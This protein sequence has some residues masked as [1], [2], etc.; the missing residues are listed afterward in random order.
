MS[1]L[2][3]TVAHERRRRET[4]EAARDA[5]W[6]AH[7]AE[8]FPKWAHETVG[9]LQ[10]KDAAEREATL[11]ELLSRDGVT[12]ETLADGQKNW[13]G[14]YFARRPCSCAGDDGNPRG[15]PEFLCPGCGVASWCSAECMAADT[16]HA[17]SCEDSRIAGG[18]QYRKEFYDEDG[19]VVAKAQLARLELGDTWH[20]ACDCWP[21]DP[22]QELNDA[23]NLGDQ[24][25]VARLLDAGLPVDFMSPLTGSMPALVTAAL[26]GYLGLATFLVDRGADVNKKSVLG[27]TPAIG[28]AQ[29]DHVDILTLLADR[30]ADL[31]A[32]DA[33]GLTALAA[34][35]EQQGSDGPVIR[36]RLAAL[37]FLLERGADPDKVD[38]D[39]DGL[40]AP[41]LAVAAQ[42]LAAAMKRG[43]HADAVAAFEAAIELLCEHGASA[44]GIEGH[45]P[46]ISVAV[47]SIRA[48]ATLL[49]AGADPNVAMLRA[50]C[51]TLAFGDHQTMRARIAATWAGWVG[52]PAEE[53]VDDG[54]RAPHTTPLV[55]V[56]RSTDVAKSAADHPSLTMLMDFGADPNRIAIAT[57][58]LYAVLRR[59]AR[60]VEALLEAGADPDAALVLMGC[61]S[62][63]GPWGTFQVKEEA[64]RLI[65]TS[66]FVR[67]HF[68]PAD[69]V[70]QAFPAVA[71]EAAAAALEEESR[72]IEINRPGCLEAQDLRRVLNHV[73][74]TNPALLG[75]LDEY[76]ERVTTRP[77]HEFGDIFVTPES[78]APLPGTAARSVW[79]AYC[80]WRQA[81]TI[82]AWDQDPAQ[83]HVVRTRADYDAA[84]AS[85]GSSMR[86]SWADVKRQLN[87]AP[88]PAPPA[89]AGVSA[90]IIREL[91]ARRAVRLPGFVV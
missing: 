1:R 82:Q 37:A 55:E 2:R 77:N 54:T 78:E 66:E 12:V 85:M 13:T 88:V 38:A 80:C 70:R 86:T 61:T 56:L 25:E 84:R 51:P 42:G 27:C 8:V 23:A 52:P 16:E 53:A 71:V 57:P 35:L 62:C 46:L 45:R 5:R 75:A 67:L 68:E 48:T 32:T 39:A 63:S 44:D 26:Y 87:E 11:A 76:L 4:A 47:S 30:G 20:F 60:A 90:S 83:N 41:P 28:A 19:D 31:D 79:Q 18:A 81:T 6:S 72:I 14:K 59:D 40:A 3:E 69:P 89:A 29:G 49:R 22:A 24:P 64:Q 15:R 34:S 73:R 21:A 33:R 43:G 58:L 10:T 65:R 74:V 7:V 9:A 91:D 17:A 36:P 50:R